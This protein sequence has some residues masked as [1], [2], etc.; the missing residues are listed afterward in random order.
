VTSASPPVSILLITKNHARYIDQAIESLE[1]Q[2]SDEFEVIVID[3][4]STDGATDRLR[5]W[6]ADTR[7]P[8]RLIVN[9][10]SLNIC[11]NRN[12]FL[13]VCRGAFV[14]SLSGDDYY[15]PDR[16]SRQL[17]FFRTLPDSVG[18][19]FS[20]ARVVS[21]GG[22]E[23]G[24]WFAS[25]PQVPEGRI[26]DDLLRGNFLSA[27]TVMIRRSVIDAVG[28]Y[29]ETL[30]YE[31]YDMFL[32]IAERYELRYLPGV[33]SN[34]RL[35]P[36]GASRSPEYIAAMS[37]TTARLLL[38]W[39]G[40]DARHDR[41]IEARARFHA[42]RAFGADR[43]RG[44]NTLAAVRRAHPSF[45]NG[46]AVVVAALPGVHA[47]VAGSQRIVRSVK[48]ARRRDATSARRVSFP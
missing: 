30:F 17:G 46:A 26:F 38:K 13:R 32:R 12:Q 43:A 10:R 34:Y 22:A 1:R 25:W 45:V 41:S 20:Q 33:V 3:D 11:E 6:V 19:I 31:D 2:T 48:Q 37:D 15:E 9:T 8:A 39:Y 24:V 14:V 29:D 35:S 44:L 27:A 4:C 36:Q 42:W 28:G 47:L 7:R 16:I 40:R 23:V 21:D 18:A 5:A